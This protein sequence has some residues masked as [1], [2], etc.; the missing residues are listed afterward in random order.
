MAGM[1]QMVV[2]VEEARG[3]LAELIAER[4]KAWQLGYS[5]DQLAAT[6]GAIKHAAE[7]L[8]IFPSGPL[9]DLTDKALFAIG[10]VK[11]ALT[12]LGGVDPAGPPRAATAPPPAGLPG[13]KGEAGK[14]P[15]KPMTTAGKVML[16]VAIVAGIAIVG[17]GLW[18]MSRPARRRRRA[19]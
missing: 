10:Q 1:G 13:P 8:N 11:G 19:A 2:T 18:F 3:Y 17:G 9:G 7:V 14:V 4:D 6:D 16:G 12:D 5:A 15:A